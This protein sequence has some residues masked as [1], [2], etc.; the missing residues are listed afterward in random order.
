MNF[1]NFILEL[2]TFALYSGKSVLEKQNQQEDEWS[3]NHLFCNSSA[4]LKEIHSE[5]SGD[6]FST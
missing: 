1:H 5:P 2:K 6:I 3:H 4:S